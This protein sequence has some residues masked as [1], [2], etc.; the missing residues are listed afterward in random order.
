MSAG[1]GHKYSNI[2]G[3]S[4]QNC[5]KELHK[6]LTSGGAPELMKRWRRLDVDHDITDLAGYNVSG[7]VRYLDRDF[8]RALTDPAYAVE[9]LGA[10]IDTGLTVDQTA[11]CVVEHEGEE[12]VIL[13]S[14][15]PIELYEPAHEFATCGEHLKVRG[16]GGTPIKYERGLAP[17]IKFCERKT[18]VKPP[19]DLACAPLLDEPDKNDLRV[20][21]ILRRLGVVD[22]SK[23]SKSDV[24]YAKADSTSGDQCRG[25]AHWQGDRSARLSLCKLV[26]G[27]VQADRWCAKFKATAA[28]M[29]PRAKRAERRRAQRLHPR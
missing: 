17:A 5:V 29:T 18:P 16:F 12:K 25:C 21:R 24:A 8:F 26:E 3:G 22:A 7:T 28:Q 15:N 14:D 10:S 6:L 11:Q 9:I 4:P 13:D 1:H 19:L 27:L 2:R 20:L 23:I